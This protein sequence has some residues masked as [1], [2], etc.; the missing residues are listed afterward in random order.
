MA[1][2]VYSIE[3]IPELA[4]TAADRLAELG[5]ANVHVQAGDGSLGWPAAAPY[6]GILVAAAAPSAPPPLLEQLADG[7]RLV[8]PVG[9]RGSQKLEIWT[10]NGTKFEHADHIPVAFVPLRGKHGWRSP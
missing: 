3:V 1:A 6:A 2:D 8:L 5:Y 10:R 9:S 7:G 4:R